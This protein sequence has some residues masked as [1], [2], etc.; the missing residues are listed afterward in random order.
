MNQANK[1]DD[2][3]HKSIREFKK[4]YIVW[5]HLY[6]IQERIKDFGSPKKHATNINI[7]RVGT[8]SFLCLNNFPKIF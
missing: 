6:T 2:A 1:I 4:Y 7:N 3:N 8:N 5:E